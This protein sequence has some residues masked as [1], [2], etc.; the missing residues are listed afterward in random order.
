MGADWPL[1]SAMPALKRRQSTG[2]AAN[3]DAHHITAPAPEGEGAQRCM[4]LA[5]A[6]AKLTP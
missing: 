2:Y 1:S 3:A 4:K 5:L 6:D